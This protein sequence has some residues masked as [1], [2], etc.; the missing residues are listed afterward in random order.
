MMGL[1]EQNTKISSLMHICAKQHK[2][3]GSQ[4]RDYLDKAVIH[5]LKLI[6][7]NAKYIMNCA[8]VTFACVFAVGTSTPVLTNTLIL[9][10]GVFEAYTCA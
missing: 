9:K 8:A 5:K 10:A 6:I 2:K 1:L 4:V 7:S 3:M